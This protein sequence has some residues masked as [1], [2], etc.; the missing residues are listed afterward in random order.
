VHRDAASLGFR[1]GDLLHR[2]L[3]LDARGVQFLHE[4]RPVQQLE[5]GDALALQPAVQQPPDPLTG[6]A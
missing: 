6:M 2:V 5:G 4:V 1:D 3:D